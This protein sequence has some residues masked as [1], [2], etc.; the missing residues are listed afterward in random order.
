MVV[1]TCL[2]CGKEFDRKSNYLEHM[3]KKFDCSPI[4]KTPNI[5]PDTSKNPP[6]LNNLENLENLEILCPYCKSTFTRKDHLKRH[7]DNRCK[8][9]KIQDEEEKKDK[10][11][12]F[13]LLL[14]KDEQIKKIEEENNKRLKFIEEEN[15]KEKENNKKLEDYVK[16][17]TDMNI[18]LNNKVGKLLEK[19]SINNISNNINNGTINNIIISKDKLV[20]FGEED[21]KEIE[22]KK[23]NKVF[24]KFGKF[25]FEEAVKNIWYDKP[26]FKNVY[27]SDLSRDKA[28]IYKDGDFAITPVNTVL[29]TINQQLFKYFKHNIDEIKKTGDKKLM[30]RVEKEVMNSYKKF[31]NAFDN[32]VDRFQPSSEQLEEF[33]KVVNSHLSTFFYN[34]KEDIKKNYEKIKKEAL[35]NNLLKQIEYKP[36]VKKRGRPK[37]ITNIEDI[38]VTSIPKSVSGKNEIK[39]ILNELKEEIQDIKN[40]KDSD[41]DTDSDY[42]PIYRKNVLLNPKPPK[43][44]KQNKSTKN[45]N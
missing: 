27:M 28:M 38:K 32:D 31:F 26:K 3:N 29:T 10:D 19:M 5:T 18:E 25:I 7:I 41:S 14:I 37:K 13:K 39:K 24:G 11:N 9:K 45:K 4:I 6:I 8:V 20:N 22:Y 12:I 23:F 34:I 33:T 30:E 40:N 2:K 1:H 44:P 15:K 16:K 17:L 36:P 21:I 43:P 42:M 35:D